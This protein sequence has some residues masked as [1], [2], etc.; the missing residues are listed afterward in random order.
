MDLQEYKK[1]FSQERID[2]NWVWIV[3]NR[4]GLW[5]AQKGNSGYWD[6]VNI[7]SQYL[8]ILR[9]GLIRK[10]F[11]ELIVVIK[12]KGLDKDKTKE[13]LKGSMDQSPISLK[14]AEIDTYNE[15]S[16]RGRIVKELEEIFSAPITF[17]SQAEEI[18]YTVESRMKEYLEKRVATDQYS[19]ICQGETYCGYTTTLSIEQYASERFMKEKAPSYILIFECVEGNIDDAT[20]SNMTGRFGFNNKIKLVIAASTGFNKR[21]KL[22]ATDRNVCLIRVNPKYEVTSNDILTPRMEVRGSVHGYERKMLSGE[23]AM[24]VPLVIQDGRFLTT[25]LTDFLK[26]CGIPVNNPSVAHA[27]YLTREFIESVVS[28]LVEDDVKKQ[29]KSLKNISLEDKVPYCIIDP[30]H[31]ANQDG[32]TIIRTDLSKMCHLGNI[33]LEKKI[34]RLSDQLSEKDPCDRFSMAHEYGHHKLHS[35]PRFREFLKRDAELEGQAA[36]DIWERR[37][38]ESQANHFASCL[39]MPKE[40]VELLYALYW[41]KWFKSDVVK[42]LYVKAPIYGDKDFQNVVGPIARHMGVS[43]EAMFIRL[44]E[45]G[46]ILDILE[47][48]MKRVV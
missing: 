5:V 40:I 44:Q 14:L 2:E 23:V 37:W 4:V 16:P 46:L 15:E 11:A 32:L 18:D 1:Y 39:L 34:V 17:D 33:D 38:L 22:L 43:L 35:H 48:D 20:I 31:Y 28:K 42:P 8:G 45:M 25:S 36:S 26:R 12:P 6:C 7:Y 41:R 29:V 47:V 3:K 9:E 19:R 30:Y 13:R 24:N 21:I 10:D 27:P